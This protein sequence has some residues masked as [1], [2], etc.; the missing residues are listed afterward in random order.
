[1]NSPW[2]S[3]VTRRAVALSLLCALAGACGKD[4]APPQAN[5]ASRPAP[6]AGDVAQEEATLLGRDVFL[7]VD[8]L[9]AYAAANQRK[10]PTSLRS[11]GIDSLTPK[12]AR[13]IDTRTKPPMAFAMFRNPLGHQLTSCRGTTDL[14]EESAL[15]DGRFTVTCTNSEGLSSPYKVQRASGR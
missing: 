5:P 15:N 13:Q 9:A 1:M 6:P 8:R 14:L 3:G 12:I 10:Y 7:L 4:K 2:S 11:A